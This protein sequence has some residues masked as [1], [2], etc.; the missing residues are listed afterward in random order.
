MDTKLG[1][2][3]ECSWHLTSFTEL[4][5]GYTHFKERGT[6]NKEYLFQRATGLGRE[7]VAK[8]GIKQAIAVLMGAGRNRGRM[9]EGSTEKGLEFPLS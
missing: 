5:Y 1:H 8:R 3:L 6:Q 4:R 7:R 2:F 9:V